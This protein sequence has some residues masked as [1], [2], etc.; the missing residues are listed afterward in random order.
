MNLC[1]LGTGVM[2][3]GIAA[4]FIQLDEVDNVI[5]WG[6]SDASLDKARVT[7]QKELSKS[8]GQNGFTTEKVSDLMEKLQVTSDFRALQKSD[9][10]IEAIKEDLSA[11]I[12]LF[13]ALAPYVQSNSIISSNTSSLSVTELSMYCPEPSNFIGLHFFN[14]TRV[15][16]LVE[17][18]KGLTTADETLSKIIKLIK[19]LDKYPVVVNDSPGFIVNRMLIPMINEAISILAEG[20]ANRDDIDNAMKFGANHP[21]GPLA[22]SDLIGN[23]VCLSI[24]SSL[25]GE[26]GDPKYRPHPLLKRYVRA[27][28]LGRKTKV[29]FYE[30]R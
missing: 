11:K 3:A 15:M 30:Y 27:D 17:V 16:K 20:V 28:K 5:V 29:G 24:M 7:I 8:I 6:R 18:I 13:K 12:E 4:Q 22:L 1:I 23:D 25:Y 2:G 10:F 21:L 19:K 26:T 14:P 9:L